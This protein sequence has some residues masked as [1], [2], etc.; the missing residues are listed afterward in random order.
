[1]AYKNIIP[2]NDNVGS[3]GTASDAWNAGYFY[4]GLFKD[5]LEINSTEITLSSNNSLSINGQ[6]LALLSDV[7]T[8]TSDLTND[9]A[10][11][12]SIN[13]QVTGLYKI[14]QIEYDN[15]SIK[16]PLTLYIIT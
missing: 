5:K 1:M 14:S 6:D 8:K 12:G 4:N 9:S 15:L 3:L 16:D 11:V 13:D 2:V 10:F 7:P